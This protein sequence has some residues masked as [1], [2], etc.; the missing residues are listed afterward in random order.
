MG[1]QVVRQPF[2]PQTF[3]ENFLLYIHSKTTQNESSPPRVRLLISG[4]P[5]RNLQ[6]N[7]DCPLGLFFPLVTVPLFKY[8]LNLST[9]PPVCFPTPTIPLSPFSAFQPESASKLQADHLI[10]L[11]DPFTALFRKSLNSL[12]WLPEPSFTECLMCQA[13]L[14]ALPAE[15]WSRPQ[16]LIFCLGW[17]G[18]GAE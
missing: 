16:S 17:C 4:Y 15:Q 3:I 8:L 12:A 11:F 1:I 14:G 9:Y 7:L 18:I 10:S 2:S 6:I 13:V 5:A